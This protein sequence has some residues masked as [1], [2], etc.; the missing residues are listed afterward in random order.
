MIRAKIRQL[1]NTQLDSNKYFNYNDFQIEIE[2]TAYRSTLVKIIYEYDIQYYIEIKVPSE[3]TT[4]TKE[5]KTTNIIGQS[6]TEDVKYSEYQIEGKMCPGQLS[7]TED[8]KNEGV[9]GIK[10]ALDLWLDHLWEDLTI[11][12][13]NRVFNAQKNEIEKIKEKV[14]DMPDEFFL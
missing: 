14:K 8:F 7:Y 13:E 5:R 3:K 12:P 9:N 1:I 10:K 11:T 6:T 2:D 4:L